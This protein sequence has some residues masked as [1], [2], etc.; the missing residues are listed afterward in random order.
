[1]LASVIFNSAFCAENYKIK[2]LITDNSD[3]IIYIQAQGNFKNNQ[4]QSFVPVSENNN[5]VRL[6]N[7]IST[8]N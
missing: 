6:M 5:T 2:D 7:S 3:R 8:M 1:M 4:T